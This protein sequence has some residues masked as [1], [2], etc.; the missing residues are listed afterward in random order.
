M[1]YGSNMALFTVFVVAVVVILNMLSINHHKRFDLTAEKLHSLSPQTLKILKSLDGPVTVYA[2]VRQESRRR[3]ADVLE[4]YD[5]ATDNFSFMVIDPDKEPALAQKYQI[6]DYDTF[7][8]ETVKG[9]KEV[10]KTLEAADFCHSAFF[11][12]IALEDHHRRCG[13]KWFGKRPNNVVV[14]DRFYIL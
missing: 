3:A 8:I 6:T 5:Y 2:F 12:E 13:I 4:R 10:I 7:V 14:T 1:V 11:R 9:R